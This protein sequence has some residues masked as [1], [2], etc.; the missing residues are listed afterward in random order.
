MNP[1]HKK[2]ASPASYSCIAQ[3][4]VHDAL[5]KGHDFDGHYAIRTT[6][7]SI[8]PVAWWPS[9]RDDIRQYV[10]SCFECMSHGPVYKFEPLH[11]ILTLQ[12]FDMLGI[13]YIGPLVPTPRGNIYILHA[14]DYFSRASKAWPTVSATEQV[15]IALLAEFFSY[16][17]KPVAVY[18]DNGKHFGRGVTK[19]LL[20]QGIVHLNSASYTPKS[21]G[22]IEK[23]NDQLEERIRRMSLHKPAEWDS[24]IDTATKDINRHPVESLGFSP[25]EIL[26]GIDKRVP[27]DCFHMEIANALLKWTDSQDYY[28]NPDRI[29]E[30]IAWRDETR[31]LT[32]ERNELRAAKTK[33]QYDAKLRGPPRHYAPGDL[34]ML[35]DPTGNASKFDISWR[36]PFRI[37][38]QISVSSYKIQ[39]LRHTTPY[40]GTYTADHLKMYIP[41]REEWERES[42]PLI[43]KDIEDLPP[44]TLRARRARRRGVV[45]R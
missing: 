43:Y 29:A 28:D 22:M 44:P 21:T 40:P 39:H 9:R 14:I 16:Y 45:A 10:A 37:V 4:D 42:D 31:E 32:T 33:E 20:D 30:A 27:L 5:Q 23:R 24:F 36:G 6:F 12:P 2:Q 8:G 34:V 17:I 3:K 25:Y 15:T 7:A 19:W 11:P 1:E 38:E 26:F 18:A 35:Y 13:D 41:R